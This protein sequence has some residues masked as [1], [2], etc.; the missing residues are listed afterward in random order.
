MFIKDT[1]MHHTRAEIAQTLGFKSANDAE[2]NLKAL[3]KKGVIKMIKLKR[4]WKM[5]NI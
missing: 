5:D 2:E 3:A 4:E 1:G